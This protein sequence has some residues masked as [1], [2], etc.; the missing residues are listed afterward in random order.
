M[1][2]NLFIAVVGVIVGCVAFQAASQEYRRIQRR[3]E[4][5]QAKVDLV[6]DESAAAIADIRRVIASIVDRFAKA[7][8]SDL[9][10]RE[11]VSTELGRLRQDLEAKPVEITKETIHE[12]PKKAS[13]KI[14]MHSGSNCAPC[15]AWIMNSLPVWQSKG[16]EIEIL[17]ETET[18]RSW[19]WFEVYLPSGRS[20]EVDGPLTIESY[21][22][23]LR[24]LQ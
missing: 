15:N 24:G 23:A 7:T 17:K 1:N 3:I 13:C 5:T 22:R 6:A 20:F 16:W 12:A 4:V 11:M 9:Q 2:R 14:V 21:E 18:T 8:D 10:F 19:P